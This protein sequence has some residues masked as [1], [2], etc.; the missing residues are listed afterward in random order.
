MGSHIR[1]A[2]V[3]K[4]L[5]RRDFIKSSG[6]GDYPNHHGMAPSYFNKTIKDYSEGKRPSP[7]MEPF[8]KYVMQAGVDEIATYFAEQKQQPSRIK[9]D[10]AAA[11]RGAALSAQCTVCHN[12]QGEGDPEKGFPV[13][14]GQPAGY[15]QGQLL[16]L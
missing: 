6:L 1:R 15:L 12:P 13:L 2:R 8:S 3:M 7:E 14:R 10:P 16:S 5:T 11:K 9:V 4:K